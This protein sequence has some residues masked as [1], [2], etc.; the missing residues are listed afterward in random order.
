M[1]ASIVL[2]GIRRERF[3]V[4][5]SCRT[6]ASA[7]RQ[8][9]KPLKP[10]MLPNRKRHIRIRLRRSW[11][12]FGCRHFARA[13]ATVRRQGLQRGGFRVSGVH[14]PCDA[15]VYR[16]DRMRRAR[17]SR[18]ETTSP[19]P[20]VG[21][22]SIADAEQPWRSRSDSQRLHRTITSS[23]RC[24]A[25]NVHCPPIDAPRRARIGGGWTTCDGLDNVENL[26]LG[27]GFSIFRQCGTAFVGRT[28]TC[29]VVNEFSSTPLGGRIFHR[30]I[31]LPAHRAAPASTAERDLELTSQAV[32]VMPRC[33]CHFLRAQSTCQANALS[34]TDPHFPPPIG[35]F[36]LTRKHGDGDR[37]SQ[38][39]RLLGD[40]K[41]ICNFL[42]R[43]S[44]ACQESAVGRALSTRPRRTV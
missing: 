20:T 12:H 13:A 29:R 8:T 5:C 39:R 10:S 32:H 19:T 36:S 41:R 26:A 4:V 6:R 31:V 24:G 18:F 14:Q 44:G 9:C 35:K 37:A 43:V 40:D 21:K 28:P 25:V 27:S 23:R 1:I 7:A 17:P 33:L 42:A 15:G 22:P 16:R 34:L 30:A 38:G 3:S 2:R 11:S